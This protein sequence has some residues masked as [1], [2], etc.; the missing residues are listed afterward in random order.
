MIEQNLNGPKRL[1]ADIGGT[2][3]RFALLQADGTIDRVLS[4]PCKDYPTIVLAISDYLQKVG[5]PPVKQGA[6]AIANPVEGD[7]IRMTNHSWS[8]SIEDVASSLGLDS[9]IFKNDFTALALSVPHLKDDELRKFGGE[10]AEPGA[11]IAVIGPGTGLGVSGLMWTG[12]KWIGISGEGGHVS[13]SP[14]SEREWKIVD[15]CRERFGHVSAERLVSGM[16]LQ[17]LYST[18]CDLDS[19]VNE[20]LTPADISCRAL[21]RSDPVCIET[22]EVFCSI[23]GSV[24]GNLAL[25]LG[26]KGGVYIGGGIVPRLGRFFTD[27]S[28]RKRFE[29]KGRFKNYLQKIPVYV[30]HAENP[31]LTG[32]STVFD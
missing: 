21:N 32:I 7:G 13:V 25:T 9:L 3:A 2:N 20:A 30:I 8:F 23:L 1:V 12:E 19:V 18:L 16:G 24:S 22:V 17:N 26:A 15:K 29:E 31:A 27:S 28:F 6:I 5:N 14:D 10:S 4:L 11:S